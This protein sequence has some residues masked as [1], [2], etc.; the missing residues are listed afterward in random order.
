MTIFALV[1]PEARVTES[2]WKDYYY[3]EQ[4]DIKAIIQSNLS[5]GGK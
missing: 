2:K 1:Y 3:G 4:K 5:G